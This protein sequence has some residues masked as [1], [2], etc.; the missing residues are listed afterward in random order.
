VKSILVGIKNVLLWS[1]ARGTWQYDALCLG[2]VLAVFLVPSRYFGDRDRIAHTNGIEIRASKTVAGAYETYIK[3]DT[4]E[5]F[6]T[7]Q[8]RTDL[9]QSPKEGVPFYLQDGLKKNVTIVDVKP[10]TAPD[11]KAIYQVW[12][13]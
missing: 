13:K 3:A 12:F 11:G 8:N 5:E 7:E 9:K 1:Y 2:I 6:L 10:F 4:L